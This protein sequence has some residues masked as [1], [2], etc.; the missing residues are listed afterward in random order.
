MSIF[1]RK[2]VA[3]IV[4]GAVAI[5]ALV[6]CAAPTTC[7]RISDCDVGFTCFSG[8]CVPALASVDLEA[9]VGE[10]SVAKSSP[11][12]TDANAPAAETS[13]SDSAA[14]ETEAGDEDAGDAGE[15]PIDTAD[16]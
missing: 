9:S 3:V 4:G 8:A 12:P 1:D 5:V 15:E 10:G 13:T 6:R 14:V 2:R 16:F 7:L 11:G